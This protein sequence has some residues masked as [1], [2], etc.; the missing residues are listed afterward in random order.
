MWF[1]RMCST[2]CT[3]QQTYSTWMLLAHNLTQMVFAQQHSQSSG[4]G[5]A[6]PSFYLDL[7][8][9]FRSNQVVKISVEIPISSVKFLPSLQ[10]FL[11]ILNK[12]TRRTRLDQ[13]LVFNQMEPVQ[14][15]KKQTEKI[16]QTSET[17]IKI[18]SNFTENI[19]NFFFSKLNLR[20][21]N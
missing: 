1:T 2:G 10:L 6:S 20:Y 12:Q 7:P 13:I 18:H 14:R 17:I 8:G 9:G 15:K 19:C 4:P 16:Q 3:C 11:L 5:S 21:R